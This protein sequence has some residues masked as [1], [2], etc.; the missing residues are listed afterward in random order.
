M[1]PNCHSL[2][3]RWH[4]VSGAGVVYS[5]ALLHHPQN[6]SFEYPVPAVLIELEEEV[7][8]VSNLFDVDPHEIY[9]GM[10]VQVAFE[11]TADG[12]AVPVFHPRRGEG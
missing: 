8:I 3:Q 10:P 1:C 9:I 2:E 12:F 11:P 4:E 7:R 6:P 5:Y